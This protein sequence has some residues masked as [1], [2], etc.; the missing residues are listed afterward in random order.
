MLDHPEIRV[1]THGHTHD[2]FKYTIGETTVVCNPRGY[3]GYESRANHYSPK[4]FYISPDGVVAFDSD[5]AE[6]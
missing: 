2:E 5:W 4:G 6:D 1:W 3:H